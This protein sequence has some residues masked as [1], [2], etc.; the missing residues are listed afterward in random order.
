MAL[1]NQLLS[2]HRR[3]CTRFDGCVAQELLSSEWMPVTALRRVIRIRRHWQ[4]PAQL[5]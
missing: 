5:N 1:V 2:T 4:L 3:A